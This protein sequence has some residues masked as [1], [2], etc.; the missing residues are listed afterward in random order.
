MRP[1]VLHGVALGFV[2]ALA[3]LAAS[4]GRPAHAEDVTFAGKSV[5]LTIGFAAGGGVDLYGRTLSKH[6][7]QKLPGGPSVVVFNK[8]GAGGVVALNDWAMRAEPNGLNVTVG[9]QSQTDPDALSRT[10]AKFDPATFKIV[11]GLGAYSQG[12]FIRKEAVPRLTDKSAPPVVMGMVGSTLRG[13]TYQVLWGAS[14][15]GWNVKWVVGYQSTGEVRQALERGEIDMATFGATKDFDYI[16]K[17]GK[18]TVISQTGQVQ[19]GKRVKRPILGDAPIFSDMV[20]DKIKEPEARS[21]FSYWEDVSQIGMWVALPAGTPDPI[22]AT[23]VKAFEA[24]TGD[25]VFQSEYAKIDP[26]SI[27]ATKADI[28]RQIGAL[29]KVSPETLKYL[30][31]ALR[32]QG[33][34]AGQ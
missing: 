32:R 7:A 5:N 20:R 24:A 28:E 4:V 13:G 17:T 31:D 30:E 34:T 3:L 10:K 15:L 18:V 6:L 21:A 19:D 33:F 2:G 12:V 27:K 29:A 23:Y 11:G 9:A 22:V 1:I 16:M 8:P 26:D 14:F 25:P